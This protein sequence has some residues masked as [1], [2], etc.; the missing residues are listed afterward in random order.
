MGW[1]GSCRGR[2]QQLWPSITQNS[3]EQE[4]EPLHVR[5]PPTLLPVQLEVLGEGAPGSMRTA[6][7]GP[8]AR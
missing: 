4:K 6:L 5:P 7:E 2:G 8:G 3:V 1:N